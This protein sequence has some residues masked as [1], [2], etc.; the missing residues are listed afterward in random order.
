V[1]EKILVIEDDPSILRGLQLNLGMEGYAVRSASDG[2]TGL[3]LA[4]T[5]RPD[6]VCVDVMLPRMGGLEVV[7]E[8]RKD[9]PDLPILI[10]SAKGQEG[11]KSPGSSSAP[12]TTS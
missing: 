9:D 7:R 5:E 4:K 3:R 6:L 11:D 1:A 12:T 10:L 2:E 8:I